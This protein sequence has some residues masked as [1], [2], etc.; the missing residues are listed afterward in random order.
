MNIKAFLVFFAEFYG[1]II[2]S[3]GNSF[4]K[5]YYDDNQQSGSILPIM[6]TVFIAI[7]LFQ[8][9]SGSHFNTSVTIMMYLVEEDRI[10]KSNILFLMPIYIVAQF[11]GGII[12]GLISFILYDGNIQIMTLAEGFT[13]LDG[14]F[15][16]FLG[17]FLFYILLLTNFH[18]EKNSPHPDKVIYA[19]ISVMGLG[20]GNA[21][22]CHYTVAGVNPAIASGFI[23]SRIMVTEKYELALL[24]WFYIL[25][26]I[27]AALS[28]TLFYF[29]IYKFYFDVK[30]DFKIADKLR[31]SLVSFSSLLD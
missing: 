18:N 1:T 6:A 7:L 9:F 29:K 8:N 24:L 11:S 15:F 30:D 31:D 23:I 22:S 10:K 16:E 12:G 2:V 26:P 3:L 27:C 21:I 4:V 14:F 28:A 25:A 19:F 17:S 5:I 20:L 13:H